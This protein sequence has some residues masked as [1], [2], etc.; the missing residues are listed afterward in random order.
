VVIT[1]GAKDWPALTKW[2]NLDYISEHFG[3]RMVTIMKIN[4]AS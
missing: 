3:E 1:D 2:Q 4:K